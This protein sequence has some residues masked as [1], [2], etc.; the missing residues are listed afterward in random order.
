M[1]YRLIVSTLIDRAQGLFPHLFEEIQPAER[2]ILIDIG[3][4]NLNYANEL[5]PDMVVGDL[6]LGEFSD[7]MEHNFESGV[8]SLKYVIIA[9][10]AKEQRENIE[11]GVAGIGLLISGAAMGMS[12]LF[13][14]EGES[15]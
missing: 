11:R 15:A 4:Q 12:L 6:S 1:N 10:I 3:E 9:R 5:V 7:R 8:R 13:G 14:G 2:E